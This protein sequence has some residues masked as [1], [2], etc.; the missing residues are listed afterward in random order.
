MSGRLRIATRKSRLALWQAEHVAAR[1]RQ[2]HPVLSVELLPMSTKG[3]RVLDRSLAKIGGKGLFI[4]ELERAMEA[5]DAD[6]A[7][8]SMKDVPAELPAGMRIAATLER[9]EPWDAFVSNAHNSLDALPSGARLGTSSLRRQ[10]QLKRRRPD[11]EVVPLR[12]NLDTRLRRLDDGQ[13][14][15]II[16]AA[17]G[18]TRLGLAER[19][20]QVLDPELCLPAVGQGV[21]GIEC[22]DGDASI[23]DILE[24]LNHES[25]A[26][27]I[28]AER[29]FSQ[30]L[31]GSC[32]SPIAAFAQRNADQLHL[33]GLVGE[34][35]GSRIWDGQRVGDVGE[36]E[37]LGRE[38]AEELLGEGV[39]E[40]LSRLERDEHG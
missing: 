20:R 29:A 14:D 34:P 40:L 18:L 11:L 31:G 5:G 12:G 35:D 26:R 4:K 13:L 32:Q 3:D 16:L 36:G 7:V 1:L 38:L 6:I 22:R 23:M 10:C 24:P 19:V 39:A 2:A 8:H 30:R 17:A 37:R 9:A 21:L 27:L 25:T 33:K 15:A 28:A